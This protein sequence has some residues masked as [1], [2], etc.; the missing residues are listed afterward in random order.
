[1]EMGFDSA[2]VKSRQVVFVREYFIM[3]HHFNV[4]VVLVEPRRMLTIGD[5]PNLAYPRR[6]HFNTPDRVQQLIEI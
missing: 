3:R 5:D 2:R 6:E 4:H 1:M